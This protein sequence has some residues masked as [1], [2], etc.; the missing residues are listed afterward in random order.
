MPTT[1]KK[2]KLFNCRIQGQTLSNKG[3]AQYLHRQS[4][5]G[6]RETT[7]RV[8]QAMQSEIKRFKEL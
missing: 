5:G 2:R 1:F 4:V 6:E 3:R 7:G 8:G